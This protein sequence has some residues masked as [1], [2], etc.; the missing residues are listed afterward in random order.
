MQFSVEPH[1][2]I[3]THFDKKMIITVDHAIQHKTL[4]QTI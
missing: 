3:I 2:L 4:S 1:E